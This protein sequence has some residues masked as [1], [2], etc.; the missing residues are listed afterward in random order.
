M[1]HHA[2][3]PRFDPTHGLGR[4]SLLGRGSKIGWF[5]SGR[6]RTHALPEKLGAGCSGSS[7]RR[8][9]ESSIF[10]DL[11]GGLHRLGKSFLLPLREICQQ[12]IF[13]GRKYFLCRFPSDLFSVGTNSLAEI[14]SSVIKIGVVDITGPIFH[15]PFWRKEGYGRLIWARPARFARPAFRSSGFIAALKLA[16]MPGPIITL[17]P[18]DQVTYIQ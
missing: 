2:E 18:Y 4:R 17:T 1:R 5:V 13:F 14:Y 12:E 11:A 10:K 8:A 16:V 3:L 6:E 7:S 15:Q 9:V